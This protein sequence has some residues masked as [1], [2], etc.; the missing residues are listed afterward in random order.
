[1]YTA[2]FDITARHYNA[3]A[4]NTDG[5]IDS[6]KEL[7][8]IYKD[9]TKEKIKAVEKTIAKKIEQKEKTFKKLEKS[10]SAHGLSNLKILK[11]VKRYR[12][13]KFVLHQKRES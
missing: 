5:K 11:I 8:K 2:K 4:I 6:V 13:I 9:E 10:I 1:M 12:N 3:I 7:Q